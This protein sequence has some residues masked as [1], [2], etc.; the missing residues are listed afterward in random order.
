MDIEGKA[1][2]KMSKYK[3]TLPKIRKTVK[4][5]QKMKIPAFEF[6][7]LFV[8]NKKFLVP[9]VDNMAPCEYVPAKLPIDISVPTATS[10]TL[11][12]TS[13]AKRPATSSKPS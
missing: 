6:Y 9:L 5:L 12:P 7:L 10:Y 4:Q 2:K 3:L 1:G 8:N 13:K 11:L